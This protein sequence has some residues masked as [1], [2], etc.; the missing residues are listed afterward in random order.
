MKTL[1]LSPYSRKMMN[2]KPNPKNY[3]YFKDVVEQLK[4]KGWYIIQIGRKDEEEIPGVSEVKLDMRLSELLSLVKDCD[5]FL[6]VDN[7][8][9]HLCYFT[10]KR[11]V[12]IYSRSDPKLFGYDSNINLLKDRK[13]LSESPW[14]I[15]E[16]CEYDENAFV[17]VDEVVNAVESIGGVSK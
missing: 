17:S 5:T 11:G 15:W 10:D 9:P 2:G 12:V 3:P 8:F 13:Y 14:D 4:E 1:V 7:F 16:N 6:S